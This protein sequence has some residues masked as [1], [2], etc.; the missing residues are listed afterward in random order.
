MNLILTCQ[1]GESIRIGDEV[2]VTIVGVDGGRV[3]I[4]IGA[5]REIPVHREEMAHRRG[6]APSAPAQPAATKGG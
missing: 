2:T 3:N 1:P 6:R 4:G 5:P